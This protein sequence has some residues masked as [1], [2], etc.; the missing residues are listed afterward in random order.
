M[1]EVLIDKAVSEK[2]NIF[3]E[4]TF[5]T[6]ATP[7]STLKKMKQAGYRTGIAIQICDRETSWKSC[8]ERYEKMRETNPL[9]ARAVD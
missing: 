2:Y 4:G 1:T 8:Q 7:V 5:R 6:S 9:L 3:V